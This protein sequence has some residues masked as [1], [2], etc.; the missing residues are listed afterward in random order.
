MGNSPPSRP[1]STETVHVVAGDQ[2]ETSKLDPRIKKE[3]MSDGSQ[4]TSFSVS[5]E[6][7]VRTEVVPYFLLSSHHPEI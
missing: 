3:I 7:Y 5:T 4:D 2:D 1:R 6:T